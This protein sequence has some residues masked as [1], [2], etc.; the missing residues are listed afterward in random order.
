MGKFQ[1]VCK[2]GYIVGKGEEVDVCPKCGAAEST[3]DEKTVRAVFR[4]SSAEAK[5]INEALA[6]R[7]EVDEEELKATSGVNFGDMLVAQIHG[8]KTPS[9]EELI[10]EAE[11]NKTGAML[12]EPDESPVVRPTFEQMYM[13][14]ALTVSQRSTCSRRQVGC[15]IT[16]KDYRRVLSIGYN[17]NAAG[18]PNRC[19]APDVSGSCGCLH[20]EENACISCAE[21]PYTPKI[22]FTTTYPCKMCAKRI[23]QLGGVFHVF[24]YEN[25]H[26]TEAAEVFNQVG[27]LA[28]PVYLNPTMRWAFT[29]KDR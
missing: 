16:T 5:R 13:R 9:L 10:K 3:W 15:V 28:T 14:F 2:C 7:F 19:D 11:R 23:I 26:D 21:S 18:L 1:G 17:G 12:I 4:P 27:I 24:Y 29:D 6:S 20:A 25:Y 8:E 22:L